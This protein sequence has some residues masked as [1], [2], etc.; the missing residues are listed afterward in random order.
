MPAVLSPTIPPACPQLAEVVSV[1]QLSRYHTNP[2]V[3]FGLDAPAANDLLLREERLLN[4]GPS[5]PG[6]LDINVVGDPL[7]LRQVLYNFTTNA[8][9]VTPPRPSLSQRPG[10]LREHTL[11]L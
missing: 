11:G 7:R 2:D 9:K 5:V 3:S 1:Q 10:Q 8:L 4:E 6:A